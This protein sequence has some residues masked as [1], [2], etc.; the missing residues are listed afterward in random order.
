MVAEER[1]VTAPERSV[2]ALVTFL[3]RH[4]D[5][6]AAHVAA[7]DATD[8]VAQLVRAARRVAYPNPVRRVVVGGCVEAGCDGELVALVYPQEPLLPAEIRCDVDPRHSWFERHWMHLSHRMDPA[9]SMDTTATT[10]RWL[11]A[12][13]I[14]RLW[15]IPAGSVYRLASEQRWRRRTQARRTYYH[16]ADVLHAVGG[17]KPRSRSADR[18]HSAGQ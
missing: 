13:D 2:A 12:A 1:R 10:T 8:E 18:S 14:S 11:S 7:A 16:E 6:I 3:G 4:V 15:S 9:P 5:W 17:R